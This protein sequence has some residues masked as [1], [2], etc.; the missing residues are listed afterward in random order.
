MKLSLISKLLKA[1]KVSLFFLLVITQNP[2]F[3]FLNKI[4]EEQDAKCKTQASYQTNDW[5]AKQTYKDCKKNF[6][7]ENKKA[8]RVK[9]NTERCFPP[10]FEE[11]ENEIYMAFKEKGEFANES[12]LKSFMRKLNL[13]KEDNSFFIPTSRQRYLLYQNGFY[14]YESLGKDFLTKKKIKRIGFASIVGK[15][16]EKFDEC[17]ESKKYF[18]NN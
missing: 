11:Y 5:S 15:F 10:L 8:L 13:N 1:S 7:K 6:I 14:D 16:I 3:A 12:K 17:I 9:R 2:S 4:T 18:D